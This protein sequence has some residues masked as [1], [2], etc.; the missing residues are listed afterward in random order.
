MHRPDPRGVAGDHGVD[1]IL[2]IGALDADL[3][4]DRDIPQGHAVDQRAVLGH[5]PAILGAG[6]AARM[7][8]PVVDRRAPGP[9][10]DRQVPEGR[11]PD[12]GRDQHLH[13]RRPGLAQIGGHGA[14]RLIHAGH[15]RVGAV[16]VGHA[17]DVGIAR[18]AVNTRAAE[19]RSRTGK[20][21]IPAPQTPEAASPFR[22]PRAAFRD[23]APAA[24][25]YSPPASSR[26]VPAARSPALARS[27]RDSSRPS[28][29]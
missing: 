7:I 17:N 16:L 27:P 11:F 21:G 1:E 9:G 23:R 15:V 12:P 2:G 13:R 26:H 8:H 10:L 14:I 19:S 18:G 28:Q 25:R 20:R 6:I 24:P 4:L 3:P 29:D 22:S 5:R